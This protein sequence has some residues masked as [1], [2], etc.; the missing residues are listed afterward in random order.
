MNT[1]KSLERLSQDLDV[2]DTLLVKEEDGDFQIAR[3]HMETR[4]KQELKKAYERGRKET[5]NQAGGYNVAFCGSCGCLFKAVHFPCYGKSTTSDD[6][7]KL[8]E[9]EK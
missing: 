3:E 8:K 2:Y 9:G 1:Q 6:L 4:F 7:E 5:Y